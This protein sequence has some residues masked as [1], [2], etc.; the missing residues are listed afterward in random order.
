MFNPSIEFQSFYRSDSW[1][2]AGFSDFKNIQSWPFQYTAVKDKMSP[3]LSRKGLCCSLFSKYLR[4][5][6]IRLTF[7]GGYRAPAP[8]EDVLLLQG[9]TPRPSGDCASTG[10]LCGPWILKLVLTPNSRCCWG[11]CSVEQGRG[12]WVMRALG[13][14]SGFAVY[15]CLIVVRFNVSVFPYHIIRRSWTRL[16]LK[17]LPTTVLPPQ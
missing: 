17:A 16:S 11:A 15:I 4:C 12:S 2:R 7:T 10:Q 8:T 9:H 14:G 5:S 1:T 6:N 3:S 13:S